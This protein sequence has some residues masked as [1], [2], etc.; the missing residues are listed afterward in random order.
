M[1][2]IRH[3]KKFA[4]ITAIIFLV[5]IVL[6]LSLGLKPSIDFTGGSLTEASYTEAP[7][8][9][10][11]SETLD[12]IGISKYS[13]RESSDES[14]NEGYIIR[15]KDLS[16][17]ERIEVTEA[18]S[19]LGEGGEI[20]RFTTI[21]PV[22]G[23]ELKGKAKWAIV[24]V[25]LV[26]VFYI[27]FAFRGLKKPV[28][29]WVYGGI[30]IFALLHDVLIPLAVMSVLGVVIGAEVDVLF[31]MALLA[32]LGYSVN[33][34]IVV[35]DRVRENLLI[36]EKKKTGVQF[37]DLVGKSLEQSFVRSIN[38]SFTTLL[39][40]LSLYFLGSEVTKNFTLILIAG[41]IAGTYS[42]IFIANPF[43]VLYAEWKSNRKKKS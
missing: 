11:V 6:I 26:I 4:I 43:L 14:G 37:R 10:L 28:S 30:T 38:T 8:E 41:V 36:E 31:I 32:V 2:V 23:E 25:V 21:G 33:D 1:F 34:T 24:A 19:E 5:A 29:S 16:E 7:A 18:V 40:L 3:I 39:V 12:D 13:I 22:I 9:E 17:E 15:T 20:I 27:A 35:F 42:S